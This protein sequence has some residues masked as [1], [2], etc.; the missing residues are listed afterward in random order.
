MTTKLEMMLAYLAGKQGKA[1]EMI[2]QELEDPSSEAS[3]W[4]EEVRRRSRSVSR[5][6][7]PKAHNGLPAKTILNGTVRHRPP[8]RRLLP[9]LGSV[10][11]ASLV[12]LALG[13]AWQARE[14][15]L[16]RLETMLAQR[17]ALWTGRSEELEATLARR[18][19]MPQTK[20]AEPRERVDRQAKPQ[21]LPDEKT[22]LA[23]AR[24]EA[25]LGEMGE[26]LR[27]VQSSQ[28]P[29][30]PRLDELRRDVERLRNDVEARDQAR[31]QESREL[32]LVVQEVLQL[33]RRL[34]MRAWGPSSMQAPLPVPGQQFE[35]IPRHHGQGQGLGQGQGMI[36]GA[37]QAPAER[38]SHDQGSF[39]M[40][41]GQG[42]RDRN[43]FGFPAGSTAPHM[44]R[45][46]GPG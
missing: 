8:A 18:V 44:Q 30:D 20:P 9:L 32:T 38:P 45:P 21:P 19:E 46:G 15:Q 34:A 4:L 36:P 6:G 1:A 43:N 11:A 31:K 13:L 40:D 23:L 25:K 39:P 3:R 33:L 29:S 35:E 5:T 10:F 24:V 28:N 12:L 41:F 16:V 42:Y 2:R 17:D 26:R 7:L 27:E 22:A 37:E 14:N